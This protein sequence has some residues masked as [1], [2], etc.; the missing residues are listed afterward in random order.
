MGCFLADDL[1]AGETDPVSPLVNT[2]LLS[3]GHGGV[4]LLYLEGH[5][6]RLQGGSWVEARWEEAEAGRISPAPSALH[7]GLFLRATPQGEQTARG[8]GAPV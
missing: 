1:G 2:A 3:R 4:S 5:R 8:P 7:Q 6:R